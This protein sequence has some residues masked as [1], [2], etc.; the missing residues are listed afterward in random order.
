[1][2]KEE[3][4]KGDYCPAYLKGQEDFVEEVMRR[5]KILGG[6]YLEREKTE[7]ILWWFKKT[8][9]FSVEYKS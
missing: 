7:G 6:S 3:Y 9:S 2:K 4:L 5:Y 8:I 1:M